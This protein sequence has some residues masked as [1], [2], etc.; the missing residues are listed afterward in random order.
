MQRTSPRRGRASSSWGRWLKLASSLAL[1]LLVARLARPARALHILA[2]TPPELFAAACGLL[3]LQALVLA[4]RWRIVAARTG[5]RLSP[6]AAVSM[7]FVGLFFNQA[8]PSAIGGDAVRAWLLCRRGTPFAAA[9]NGV[10]LDRAVGVLTLVLLCAVGAFAVAGWPYTILRLPGTALATLAATAVAALALI[11]RMPLIPRRLRAAL[12]RQGLGAQARAVLGSRALAGA[13]ALSAASQLLVG[14]AAALLAHGMGFTTGFLP[15][16]VLIFWML[17]V[18]MLP[19]SVGGWGL[20]EIGAVYLLRSAAPSAEHALALS[21]SLGL[22]LLG[23]SLPGA[24]FWLTA[25]L[26]RAPRGADLAAGGAARVTA[27][28]PGAAQG[29]PP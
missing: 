10:I 11:D 17:L 15:L 9:L 5:Y 21:V 19:L 13:T 29:P 20:R 8:L 23:A 1:L 3:L 24:F 14:C 22:A 25:P 27:A 6:R 7:T 12:A 4:W 16:L 2:R 18:T 26:A 28:R